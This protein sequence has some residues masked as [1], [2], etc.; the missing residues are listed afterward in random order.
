MFQ[1]MLIILGG[2]SWQLSS[3]P[4]N[5]RLVASDSSGIYL[6]AAGDG[7]YTSTSG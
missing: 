6:A 4:M 3:A 7:I 5:S 2:S 1:L